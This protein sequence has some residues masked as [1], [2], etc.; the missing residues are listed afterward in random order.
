MLQGTGQTC[1]RSTVPC[2]RLTL[3]AALVFGAFV[4][5]AHGGVCVVNTFVVL[6]AVEGRADLV[7][8]QRLRALS[9]L[10]LDFIGV[11]DQNIPVGTVVRVA[12]DFLR[13]VRQLAIGDGLRPPLVLTVVFQV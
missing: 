11:V 4:V 9:P 6:R 3:L 5:L 7:A 13:G 1:A 12:V 8:T 2:I 10:T